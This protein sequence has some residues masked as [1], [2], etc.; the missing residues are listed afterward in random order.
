M[1]TGRHMAYT[2]ENE[3]TLSAL[4]AQDRETVMTRLLSDRSQEQALKTLESEADRLMYKA[5]AG[6]A[7]GAQ[8][9]VVQGIL[10]TMKSALPLVESVSET[11]IWEKEASGE[12]AGSGFLNPVSI[13]FLIAGAVCVIAGLMGQ[14]AAGKILSPGA[15]LWTAAGCV[16]LAAGGYFAGK[17]PK[18]RGKKQKAGSVEIKEKKQTFLVDPEKV[19]HILQGITLSADH[20]LE[21]VR[22][23][24]SVRAAKPAESGNA[25]MPKDD[26]QFF[27]D[28][29]E[30]AY[31]RR[32]R[33]PSDD[34]LRE[35]VEQIRYYLHTKGIETE[36]YSI[37]SASWFEL[38]PAGGQAVTIRPAMIKDGQVVRK[39]LA[40][41]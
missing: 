16:L 29:L 35:Q 6:E 27:C 9:E 14:S 2:E 30:N 34:S 15:V 26:L 3:M 28:L 37:Q 41:A 33:D 25:P 24:E 7:S 38:L 31:A 4:L 23:A 5:G 36:D 20:S 8:G 10:Q 19:W 22:E 32:R 1:G 39:G 12:S 13:A 17:G 21:G 18:S 40:S 11:E